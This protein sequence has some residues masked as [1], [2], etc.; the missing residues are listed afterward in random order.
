MSSA[1]W[2]PGRSCRHRRRALSGT[3]LRPVQIEAG[4]ILSQAIGIIAG[5]FF[6]TRSVK[7][8]PACFRKRSTFFA[9]FEHTLELQ[10]IKQIQLFELFCRQQTF[11]CACLWARRI[12]SPEI[13]QALS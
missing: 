1:E 13:V 2:R 6:G 7:E 3:D 11:E 12:I 8:L 9:D 5:G 10:A 4:K